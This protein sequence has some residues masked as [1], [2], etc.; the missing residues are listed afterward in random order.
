ML[1]AT[2][3]RRTTSLAAE[4]FQYDIARARKTKNRQTPV[5]KKTH[6]TSR[7]GEADVTSRIVYCG[8]DVT[9]KENISTFNHHNGESRLSIKY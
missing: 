7:I 2:W 3:R 8:C 5:F 4:T 6:V 9:H 1:G